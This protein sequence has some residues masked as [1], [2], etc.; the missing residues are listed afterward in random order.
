M[1]VRTLDNSENAILACVLSSQRDAEVAKARR[2][3]IKILSFSAP[4]E[5]SASRILKVSFWW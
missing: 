4:T 3:F 2:G 5:F 1:L